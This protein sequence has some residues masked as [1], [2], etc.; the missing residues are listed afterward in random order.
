MSMDNDFDIR[1]NASL[2]NDNDF[3]QQLRPLSFDDFSGQ[4]KI[5]ENL[6]VFVAAAKMRNEALD[7]VLLHGPQDLE[8]QHFQILLPTN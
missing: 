8:K 5:V 2:N 3:E 4:P 7:H 6:E 1:E